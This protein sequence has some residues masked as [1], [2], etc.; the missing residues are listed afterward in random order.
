MGFKAEDSQTAININS[1]ADQIIANVGNMIA[2][3]N[4]LGASVAE[5]E[6]DGNRKTRVYAFMDTCE[7]E[8]MGKLKFQK[9]LTTCRAIKEAME[10]VEVD[11]KG[12]K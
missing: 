11:E 9:K 4:A 8:D 10:S 2:D 6:A 12:K 5:I 7:D 3:V 1:L